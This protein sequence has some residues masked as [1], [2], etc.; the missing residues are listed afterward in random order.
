M[1][2]ALFTLAA[3]LATVQSQT[4]PFE[5]KEATIASV[6]AALYT[7]QNTCRDVVSAFIARIEA[8][9]PLINAIITLNPTV[10]DDADDLDASLARGNATGSL[11]CV[12]ILLKDNYDAAGMRTTAG[13]A[14]LN[15]S[16]PT[17]DSPAVSAFRR[18]GAIILGKANL[19]EFALEGLSVSSLGGQTINPYDF[20]R[21]P[22]GS[23]GGTG[24]AV[25]ASFS[26]FGTGELT[27]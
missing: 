16:F 7:H 24:A 13:C 6:H 20:T 8:Y 9:N 26:V 17:V 12:P 19:H 1:K 10:L 2:I 4:T 18:A 14:A 3:F 27:K 23:S 25:A 21:T 5:A 11:F 15:D 22:G